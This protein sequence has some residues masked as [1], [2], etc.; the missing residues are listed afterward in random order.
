MPSEDFFPGDAVAISRLM[1]IGPVGPPS[2]SPE[3]LASIL[4]HQLDSPLIFDLHGIEPTDENLSV[5]LADGP[6][7]S[8]FGELFAHPKPPLGLLKL[9]KEF[10]NASDKGGDSPLPREVATVLYFAAIVVAK[11][12]L[13]ATISSLGVDALNDGIEWN[14]RQNWIDER[15]VWIFRE[16]RTG[17]ES[18]NEPDSEGHHRRG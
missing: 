18:G 8:T 12:R 4:K 16:G 17:L 10:G 9:A 2:W 11:I 13:G 3:D 6:R 1:E 14:L 5:A 7:L 15:L